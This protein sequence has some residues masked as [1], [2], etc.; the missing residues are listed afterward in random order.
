[1]F[2]SFKEENK[3]RKSG[4]KKVA[5]IDEV[6]RGPL[7][8]PVVACAFVIAAR[9]FLRRRSV[10]RNIKD[11]KQLSEKQSEII[12]QELTNYPGVEWGIGIVSEKIID[13]I[14]ILEATKLAMTRAVKNLESKLRGVGLPLNL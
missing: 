14:N 8:G 9:M 2:P 6:G 13:K 1:M 5:G 10:L 3:L 11:S 7:A 4:Y 12:Y